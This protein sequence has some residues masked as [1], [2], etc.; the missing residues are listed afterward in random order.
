VT[1]TRIV[2]A[3]TVSLIAAVLSGNGHATARL[4]HH[5]SPAHPN[6]VVF[7]VDDANVEDIDYM[8]EV[9]ARLVDR[10]VTFAKNYSPNQL[11]C[12]ARATA[13][14]G[15]YSHNTGVVDNV[16]PLG[17]VTAFDDASTLAT[18]L[19]PDYRTAFVGKYLNQYGQQA[20]G[21]AY[22][23]PGWDEWKV[24]PGRVTYHYLGQRLNA[25]GTMHDFS[26]IYSTTLYG[27]QSRAFLGSGN[28]DPFFLFASFVGPHA[29]S[30]HEADD[31]AMPTPY[32]EPKYQNTY[33]GPP[34]PTDTSVNEADISDKRNSFQDTPPLS[35]EKLAEISEALVQRREAMHSVDD[36]IARIMDKVAAIGAGDDTYYI[37][38]SDNGFFQGQHRIPR[39][40]EQPYESDA[41]VPLIIA[42]PGLPHDAEVTQVSGLQDIAP[43]VLSMANEW[44]SQGPA[45][46]DGASLMP[47][48]AGGT[49]HR[50]QLLETAVTDHMSDQAAN[51]I[52]AYG[53]RA[54]ITWA[55]RSIVTSDGWKYIA[56][57]QAGEIELYDLNADPFELNNLGRDPDYDGKQASLAARLSTLKRCSGAD[58]RR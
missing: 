5:S 25:N 41:R 11:C 43:T 40:K 48:A 50:A 39:G 20:G 9:Q 13:L 1:R 44:G 10:G 35:D 23:P 7:M 28:P 36:Q 17:G 6:V 22:V 42:G 2:A 8:P 45:S 51:Q 53:S 26:G 57:P 15:N 30:P 34:L 24:P 33:S 18:W 19:D 3:V 14:T 27:N 47:L 31:P 4:P 55:A 21:N 54:T 16:A 56:Y 46:I 49:S 37:F 29:G 38:V 58:C 12:P 52:A 32:V